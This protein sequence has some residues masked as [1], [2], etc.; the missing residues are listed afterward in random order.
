MNYKKI[1]DSICERGQTRVLSTKVY[2]EKH[3]MI[4]RCMGGSDDINNITI[5]TAKEHYLCHYIL[6]FKLYPNHH[7]LIKAIDMMMRGKNKYI[8]TSKTFK[9]IKEQNSKIIKL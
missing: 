9:F 5:L 7:G 1:Y 8:P 6:A 2:T 3:H 4:P